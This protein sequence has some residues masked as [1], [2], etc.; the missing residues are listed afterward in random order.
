[1]DLAERYGTQAEAIAVAIDRLW[2]QE[3][4][5]ST[6]PRK[7]PERQPEPLPDPWQGPGPEPEPEP[8]P[9]PEL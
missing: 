4:G 8:G 2:L 7:R 9:D 5:Q 3:V 6:Q 1:M